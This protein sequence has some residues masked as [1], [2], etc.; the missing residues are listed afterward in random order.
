MLGIDIGGSGS[1]VALTGDGAGRAE[2]A[3]ER[4]G[5][6]AAGS[7]VPDAVIALVRRALAEWPAA[8]GDLTGVGVG[9]TGLAT[10]VERPD[11]LVADVA[12]AVAE[13]TGRPARVAIAIDAVTA[14][15][16]A[17]GGDSGAIIALGT[18]AIAFGTDGRDIWRRVD[19]WGH[20]LGDR[21]AG[22]WIGM[23]GLNEAMRAY[24]DVDAAGT[25]LLDAARQRFGDPLTWPGQL[26]TRADR[27]GV[28]ASFATDVVAAAADGD[29]AATAIV[30]EAGR[31]AARSA[32]AALHPALPP[33]IATTGGVFRA[34]GA[35][36]AAFE[37]TLT[38][39]RPDAVLQASAGDPLDG[40][41]ILAERAA[42]GAI[43]THAPYVWVAR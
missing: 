10:L 42:T 25:V 23:Q 12:A 30:A 4:I 39:L 3:G 6:T 27:A 38:A 14:H 15:L 41:L 35:L 19:G 43:A 16:G 40:A 17:L 36:T 8:A 20:L 32:A 5:I 33:V 11:D 31:E 28:L 18:G 2:F 22:A 26:Y 13:A 29:S 9:A 1:R 24:D 21:G 7:T 37:Q 34:G